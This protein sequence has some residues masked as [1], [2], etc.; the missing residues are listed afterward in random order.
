MPKPWFALLVGLALASVGCGSGSESLSFSGAPGEGNDAAITTFLL[1]YP[2]IP[3][4]DPE[5]EGS[6]HEITWNRWHG[7]NKLWITG[8]LHDQVVEVA[9]DGSH[10]FH[11]MPFN[12]GP[13][14]IEFD[15][16]GE[17]MVSLEY[18]HQLAHLNAQGQ[19]VETFDVQADPHGLGIDPD[20][21]TCWFTGKTANTIGKL[22]PDGVVRNFPLATPNALPI[23][24]KS[25]PDGNMWFTEL[26]GNKIGR[27]TPNGEISE[28]PI[29]TPNS[30]PI[31]IRPEPGGQ[32][33]WFTEEAGNKLG[34]I[35]MQG[36][37]LEFP[38]P[39]TQENV[40]LASLAFDSDSNLWVQQYVDQA[41]P[42]PQ[43]D[44]HIIKIDR[45]ILSAKSTQSLGDFLTYYKVP[46]RN[47]VM[48]RITQGPDGNMWFTELKQD[49]V[50]RLRR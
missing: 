40:I 42:L 6:T 17:L 29:P 12:S 39:K 11:A 10:I 16:R 8:E 9:L 41:N 14:G 4:E 33:M 23:Y 20:G 48:H 19:I 13:H 21:L 22:S 44:D 38:V 18:A 50:G 25:G 15:A 47:T 2:N 1:K 31:G 5:G 45:R 35:D 36:N 27:V 28:F 43:G 3:R 32:A 37:I 24:I 26:T 46:D 7:G 34:R 49:R 30:R